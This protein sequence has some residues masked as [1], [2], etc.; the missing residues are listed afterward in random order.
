MSQ[1]RKQA[2]L[3]GVERQRRRNRLVSLSAIVIVA[4]VVVAVV[5]ALPRSSSAVPLPGY[6]DRC[7]SS[8]IYHAHLGLTIVANGSSVVIPAST[9]IQGACNKPIHT[10]DTSGTLHI[11]TDE[12]RQYFLHDFFLIWGNQEN[13]PERAIFNSTQLFGGHVVAGQHSLTM[14]VNGASNSD[15]QNF[16]IPKNSQTGSDVCS[17]TPCVTTNV[18]ITYT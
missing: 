17:Q 2:I 15:F 7:I 11:E 8:A 5:I 13:N 14:T 4:I 16:A 10:H 12:N 18:V 9:G 3:E 1:S 6:L